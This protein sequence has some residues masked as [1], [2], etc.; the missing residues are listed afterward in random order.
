MLACVDLNQSDIDTF[1]R[2]L[3]MARYLEKVEGNVIAEAIMKS[4]ET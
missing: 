2:Y 4:L 3:A 1:T